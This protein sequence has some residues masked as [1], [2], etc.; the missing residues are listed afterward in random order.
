MLVINEFDS[1]LRVSL[2]QW[3][4]T[5]AVV[6]GADYCVTQA[7]ACA[8][9]WEHAGLRASRASTSR[10]G[11]LRVYTA[12]C[13]MHS[14]VWMYHLREPVGHLQQW[15]CSS[16][17]DEPVWA[18][19]HTDTSGE[20]YIA[21]QH[22]YSV[23][24]LYMSLRVHDHS[25]IV[26]QYHSTTQLQQCSSYYRGALSDT[27]EPVFT[28]CCDQYQQSFTLC[29][30]CIH[31]CLHSFRRLI[32]SYTYNQL[33]LRSK[34]PTSPFRILASF[35][36]SLNWALAA[37]SSAFKYTSL[38]LLGTIICFAPLLT[39]LLASAATWWSHGRVEVVSQ[40]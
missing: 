13:S 16:L 20:R 19:H 1:A 14:V 21:A 30:Y 23:V 34:A 9:C 11:C 36:R 4:A 8:V 28:L 22:N 7:C 3:R 35:A 6:C 12:V 31:Q 39:S 29:L 10:D 18:H 24:V 17:H 32:C 26:A 2:R 5:Q 25:V 40:R 38:V 15:Q 37:T 33:H 27:Y